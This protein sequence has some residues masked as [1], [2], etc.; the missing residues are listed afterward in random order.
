MNKK[1]ITFIAIIMA[2]CVLVLIFSVIDISYSQKERLDNLLD[3]I[4]K[5]AGI[6]GFICNEKGSGTYF[7]EKYA[8]PST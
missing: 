1:K 5:R 8:S 2:L 4:I 3:K 7:L 6:K